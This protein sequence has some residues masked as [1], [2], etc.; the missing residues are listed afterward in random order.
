MWQELGLGDESMQP[1]YLVGAFG[2]DHAALRNAIEGAFTE[3]QMEWYI[4]NLSTSPRYVDR[5]G[6]WTNPAAEQLYQILIG[7]MSPEPGS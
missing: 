2:A 5:A 1:E 7:G 4:N 3:E 6:N